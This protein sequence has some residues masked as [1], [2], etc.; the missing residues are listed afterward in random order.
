MEQGI[1]SWQRE[2]LQCYQECV[3]RAGNQLLWEATPGAG[4]TRAALIV[5]SRRLRADRS[6]RIIVVVP[7][8][9][10]K[11]Q[12]AR[13]AHSFRIHLD[14][15]YSADRT[16]AADFHGAVI[17]YQQLANEAVKLKALAARSTVLLDEVHHAGDGLTWGDAIREALS[18][19]PFVLCLSGTAFRSDSNAIPFVRYNSGG[20]SLPDY[21]Y[22]YSRA[23][24]EGVCRPTAFFAYGGE[25]AWTFEQAAM[26]AG[27]S[28]ELDKQNS[29]RRLRAA[30]D[31]TSGWLDPMIRDAHERLLGIRKQHRDAGALLVASNR[32]HAR[33]FA[34]VL[35]ETTKTSPVVVLSDDAAASQKIKDFAASDTP[36]LVACNMVSEGVDIPRLRIGVYGTT[37]R[38]RM[39]FRQFLGRIVRRTKTPAGVQIAYCYLPADKRLQALAR[40][41]ETEQRHRLK[42]AT[43]S[44]FF[45]RLEDFERE[46]DRD[47]PQFEAV[48][49]V[50]SGV[51]SVIVN[52]S[53]LSLFDS[54]GG[55]SERVEQVELDEALER[56]VHSRLDD[57]LLQSELKQELSRQIKELVGLYHRKSGQPY[58]AIHTTLN[59]RQRVKSQLECSMKQL[60]ER[61]RILENL[62]AG[63]QAPPRARS[64]G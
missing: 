58:A 5:A 10:L 4:K 41:I 55:G 51:D 57:P 22:S 45:D 35:R 2:A 30:L 33:A 9:H 63:D 48:H 15:N 1:R 64:Q 54:G 27:F 8:A 17:T 49:A 62:L 20:E 32:D 21:T 39:Y 13:S 53:Q 36:W 50:N 19:A 29:A 12:W 7:T 38:T 24:I 31:P 6:S 26:S 25:V 16:L 3:D 43:E 46:R 42:A 14:T 37:I 44:D 47:R 34:K 18:P 61:M 60:E 40:E 52:G 59:K 23:I 28:D 11:I 56:E